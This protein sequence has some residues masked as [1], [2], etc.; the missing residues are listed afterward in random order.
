MAVLITCKFDEDTIENEVAIISTTFS[1]SMG[2]SRAGNYHDNSPNRAKIE[3]VQDFMSVP[4]ICKFDE[5]PIKNEVA[6]IR[7]TFSPLYV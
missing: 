6:V 4:V 5:E 3:L 1:E 2:H 7:T